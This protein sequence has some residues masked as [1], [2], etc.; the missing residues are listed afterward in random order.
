MFEK[1]LKEILEKNRLTVAELS[2]Q[3]GVPKTNIQQWLTGT[4]PN[5]K[6]IDKVASF[7]NM[8]IEELY[9]DR[10]PKTTPISALS[11]KIEIKEGAYRLIIE[12]INPTNQ[13][14]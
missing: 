3:T 1:K 7:F 6:Q 13:S 12:K 9:F 5:I 11:D 14:L 2:R 8:T 4:S 10:K